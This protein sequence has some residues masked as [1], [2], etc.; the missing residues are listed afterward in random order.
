MSFWRENLVWFIIF[1]SV[2]KVYFLKI[3][4]NYKR[5]ALNYYVCEPN[6]LNYKPKLLESILEKPTIKDLV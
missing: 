2:H 4:F 1:I 3:I 6:D 5:Y